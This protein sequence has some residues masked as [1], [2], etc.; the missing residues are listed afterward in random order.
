MTSIFST[1]IR[2]DRI[3]LMTLAFL[4]VFGITSEAL[5]QKGPA[6]PPASPEKSKISEKS[7]SW[8]Q[9]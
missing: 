8:P 6:A 4:L 7:K 1:V 9:N 3:Q 2:I 5:A